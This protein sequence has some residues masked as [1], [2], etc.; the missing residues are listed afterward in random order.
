MTVIGAGFFNNIK[1][2]KGNLVLGDKLSENS[3][4]L[5]FKPKI[6]TAVSESKIIIAD[7]YGENAGVNIG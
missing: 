4:F 6:Y 5:V 7:K 3:T 2:Q 1:A